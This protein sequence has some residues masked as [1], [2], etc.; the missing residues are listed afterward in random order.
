MKK[1]KKERAVMTYANQQDDEEVENLS[2]D[3][4][5]TL[6]QYVLYPYTTRTIRYLSSYHTRYDTWIPLI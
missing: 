6:E 4:S 3:M 5:C 1:G 2:L